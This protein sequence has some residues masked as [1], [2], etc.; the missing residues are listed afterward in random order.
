MLRTN[1][2]NN[3]HLFLGGNKIEKPQKIVRR[4]AKQQNINFTWYSTSKKH[5][6]SR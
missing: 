4:F 3:A 5:R 2:D 1:S 6:Q